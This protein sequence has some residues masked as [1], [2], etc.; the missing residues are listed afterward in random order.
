MDIAVSRS[1]EFA[2]VRV[3]GS[4]IRDNQAELRTKLEELIDTGIKGVALDFTGVDYVDSSGMGC[5]VCVL[6]RMHDRKCG[7]VVVFGAS[8]DI[9][10]VWKLI[11]LDVVIPI[12][13]TEHEALARLRAAAEP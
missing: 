11:R 12:V 8:D 4:V 13:P 1:G 7:I 9:V 10:R 5:C 3:A 2:I 6:R